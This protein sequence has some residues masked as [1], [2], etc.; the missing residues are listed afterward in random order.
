MQ[1]GTCGGRGVPRKGYKSVSIRSEMYDLSQHILEKYRPRLI[2]E[3][4][5]SLSDLWETAF[6]EWVKTHFPN[7]LKEI[8]KED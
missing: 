7:V 3:R 5:E 8:E 6:L 2:L 4:I 1:Y